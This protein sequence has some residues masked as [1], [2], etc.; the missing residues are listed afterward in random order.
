MGRR[1]QR[2]AWMHSEMGEREGCRRGFKAG[3]EAIAGHR[4]AGDRDSR[5]RVKVRPWA[6]P[7]GEHLWGEMQFG[8]PCDCPC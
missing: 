6:Q 3:E 4:E 7:A 8:A 2:A 1:Q 5:G